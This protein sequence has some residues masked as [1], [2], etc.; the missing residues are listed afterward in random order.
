MKIYSWNMLYR[1]QELDRAFDFV[2]QSDFDVFCLQEVPSA[3]LERLKTLPCAI[4]YQS[5]RELLFKGHTIHNY[6]VIL[7]KH[8]IAIQGDI[9]FPDYWHLLPLRTRLFV[10][11][12][13]SHLFTKIRNRAAVYVDITVQGELIRIFNLHLIL[14]HP[15]LRLQEFEQAMTLRNPAQKTIVCG[16]FNIIEKPHVTPLNWLLGGTAND[17]LLYR[18]ERTHIERRFV[19]H[20]L[21]N[22]L[23]GKVTHPLSQ[24]Q[25]DHILVSTHF[26]IKNAEVLH[27]RHGSDHN[28]ISAEIE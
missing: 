4:A 22:A 8:P 15:E 2:S 3:F 28:P 27:D 26:A 24:S 21:D 23:P 9:R 16:D 20:E 18:R 17:T 6:L 25:L 1:N 7:S 14:A 10:S 12:M 11:I 5:E 19:E 13:S